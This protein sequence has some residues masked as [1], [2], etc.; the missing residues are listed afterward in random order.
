MRWTALI[1]LLYEHGHYNIVFAA[2][3][4]TAGNLLLAEEIKRWLRSRWLKTGLV[5]RP[6]VDHTTKRRTAVHTIY[7]CC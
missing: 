2:L 1:L 6:G 4:G 3:F 7:R 5:R